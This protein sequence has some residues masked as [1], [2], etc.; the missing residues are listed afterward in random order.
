MNSRVIIF[1]VLFFILTLAEVF[2]PK[3]QNLARRKE[4]WP[5]N[6][7]LILF[8][9]IFIYFIF[10]LSAMSWAEKVQDLNIGIFNRVPGVSFKLLG[11]VVLMDLAIYIQH[12]VF[13]YI[14]WAWRLHRVHH[15]DR[16]LDVTSAVRFHPI[17]IILSMVIKFLVIALLGADP[18]GVLAFEVILNATAMFNHAN[19]A[20]PNWADRILRLFI[21]TPD[22]HRLHHSIE[23]EETNSNFGFNLPWWDYLFRTYRNRGFNAEENYP[24]GVEGYGC[25]NEDKILSLLQQPFHSKR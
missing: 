3:R 11:T 9:N 7:G 13:H 2:L 1:L 6:I 17:E 12:L 24:L 18:M 25:E 10:P 14:P 16:H 19:M 20:I 8:G 22:M 23:R 15:S 5:S 4:R 21:V